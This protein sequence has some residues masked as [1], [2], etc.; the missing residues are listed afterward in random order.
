VPAWDEL[1][2]VL[3]RL[4]EEQPGTLMRYPT[5]EVDENRQPPYAIQLAPWAVATAQ[6]L[7]RQFGDNVEVT[8]GALPYP[9][10]REAPRP[11]GGGQ[12]ADLLNPHEMTAELDGP[13]VVASGDTLVLGLL[14][15]NLTQ[16]EVQIATNGH[17]TAV[18]VDPQTGEVVGGFSGAQV[19]PLVIFRVRPG[20]AERVPLLIGTASF[21]PRL[22]YAV[23]P[24]Q[25]G[26]Q[27]TLRF[28]P[29]PRD[30]PR[31]RTPVMP[32]TITAPRTDR[33]NL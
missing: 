8:V 32:L 24:G 25:W 5:P 19:A 7:H 3:V 28:G 29:D 1:K 30:S 15:H 4:R 27:A 22:G 33:L 13:A 18:V 23:P 26:I 31:R 6:Y 21:T 11:R 17:I 9:P 12:P 16:V 20:R 2:P 14:L 10:G